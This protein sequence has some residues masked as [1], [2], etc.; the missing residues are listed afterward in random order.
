[1]TNRGPAIVRRQQ[2]LFPFDARIGKDNLLLHA[3]ARHFFV[4]DFDGPLSIKGVLR[5]Q[6]AW[7][8]GGRRL[9]VDPCGFLVLNAGDMYSIEIDEHQ[10]VETCCV[11]FRPGFVERVAR[12]LVEPVRACLD[13]P[14]RIGNPIRFASRVHPEVAPAIA[15]RLRALA[16]RCGFNEQ[17][18]DLDD[19]FLTLST[20]LASAHSETAAQIARVPAS[21]ASTR[22]ELFRRLQTAR[23]FLHGCI[24]RPV[25]LDELARVASLSPFHLQRAFRHTFHQT[26][27]RYA[28]GLKVRRAEHLLRQGAAVTEAAHAV[29][30]ESVSS[31]TR[32]FKKET[33]NVPSSYQP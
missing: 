6:V 27:H 29:G 31:F 14:D 25:S 12:D 28:T 33:G 26:P 7:N 9:V 11:F 2:F 18:G 23:E 10:P 30:F 15:R 24:D 13:V 8:V 17:P 21:K 32:V 4:T 16:D 5:G 22:A 19:N 1:M 3:R 20:I